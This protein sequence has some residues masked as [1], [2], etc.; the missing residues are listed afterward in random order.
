[1]SDGKELFTSVKETLKNREELILK[2][3]KDLERV[4]SLCS[5]L[6]SS[7]ERQMR[8]GTMSYDERKG[9]T[10]DTKVLC[11]RIDSEVEVHNH[12]QEELMK[13]EEEEEKSGAKMT[14]DLR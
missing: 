10:N 6:L 8:G 4:R 11:S 7:L 1:M 12:C 13:Y 3:D 14:G 9:I 5:S 2:M